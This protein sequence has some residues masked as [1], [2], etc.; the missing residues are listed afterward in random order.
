MLKDMCNFLDSLEGVVLPLMV[1]EAWINLVEGIYGDH[2]AHFVRV[3]F[4]SDGRGGWILP[5]DN[6][7][8]EAFML[9]L[10]GRG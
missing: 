10:R 1:F 3:Q 2:A 7:V 4:E 9:A 6:N 8:V 5:K